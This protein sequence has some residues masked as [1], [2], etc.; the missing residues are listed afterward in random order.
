MNNQLISLKNLT[1]NYGKG[2]TIVHALKD[3]DLVIEKKEFIAITGPSGS[4]KSTLLNIIGCMDVHSQ[5]EYILS[6]KNVN[7]SS[8]RQ[9]AAFRNSM[10]GFVVQDFALIEHFTVF[11]NIELPLFYSTHKLSR[12][13]RR[14]KCTALICA[15]GLESKLDVPV[16]FLSGGQKQRVAIGR[17]IVNDPE[18]ILADEPTGALDKVTSHEIMEMLSELNRNGKTILV[19]THDPVVANYCNRAIKLDDGKL[20]VYE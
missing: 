13:A 9:M 19:V 20:C 18:V 7:N 14:E 8:S 3:I 5:G 11:Q 15:L 4:G 17:A 16:K 12:K 2:S 10:F 1:K 6:G